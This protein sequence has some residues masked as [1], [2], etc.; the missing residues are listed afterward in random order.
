MPIV[1]EVNVSTPAETKT[2]QRADPGPEENDPASGLKT[3][4]IIICNWK[5]VSRSWLT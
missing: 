4:S 3:R 2:I 5:T 1:I